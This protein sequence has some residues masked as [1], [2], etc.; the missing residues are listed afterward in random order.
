[1]R[2]TLLLASSSVLRRGSLGKPSRMMMA[3]SVK[4]MLSN[5]FCGRAWRPLSH[6]SRVLA[7]WLAGWRCAHL[8]GAQVFNLPY[9]VPCSE[10]PSWQRPGAP[11]TQAL[12]QSG[13]PAAPLRSSS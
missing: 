6:M 10:E 3:L 1:M 5:W 8:G 4:S 12:L 11:C 9:F 7:A 13:W 2:V